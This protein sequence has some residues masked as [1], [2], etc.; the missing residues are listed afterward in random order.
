MTAPVLPF[1]PSQSI[2]PQQQMA[3]PMIDA[4]QQ[5]VQSTIGPTHQD[6]APSQANEILAPNPPDFTAYIA[7]DEQRRL[8]A[9]ALYGADF[10]A[11]N[12]DDPQDADWASWAQTR[13]GALKG[14][15][16]KHMHLVERNRL[17]RSGQQWVSSR[18]RGPWREPM[19]PVDSA[20][21]V[22][23]MIDKALDQRL[24]ISTDQRPG[25]HVEPTSFDP[26]EKRKAEARQLALESQYDS[27]T[28]T[29]SAKSRTSGR[30]LMVSPSG[31][32]SGTLTRVRGTS[33]WAMCPTN[34]SRSAI[35]TRKR[36]DVSRSEFRRTPRERTSPTTSSSV[37][38]SRRWKPPIATAS[39]E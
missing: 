14:S 29:S 1:D 26:E 4:I 9:A 27:R 30:R 12:T 8:L 25:F 11:A 20:R 7:E 13:W 36:S 23:N 21:V 18:G 28:W 32:R 2:T 39:L 38:S 3:D 33:G 10:P 19:K 16:E 6:A 31:T 34:G 35:S 37:A 5:T 24:Q 17:F 15:V 22:Y